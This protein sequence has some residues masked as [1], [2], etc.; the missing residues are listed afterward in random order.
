MF[1]SSY[2]VI[3]EIIDYWYFLGGKDLARKELFCASVCELMPS[4]V[5][6]HVPAIYYFN[7]PLRTMIVYYSVRP[8]PF[9][10]PFLSR[11]IRKKIR[12]MAVHVL[13]FA[14]LLVCH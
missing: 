9:S 14:I 3:Y 1:S 12:L 6:V 5:R 10:N 4:R 7:T 13:V 8:F 2:S 11:I